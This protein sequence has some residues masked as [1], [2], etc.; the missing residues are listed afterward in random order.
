MRFKHVPTSFDDGTE[1]VTIIIEDI[2][3]RRL[4]EEALVDREQQYRRIIDNM[5]D[6]FYRTDKD[7]NLV[8]ISPGWAP[9]LGYDSFNSVIGRNLADVFYLDPSRR[10]DFLKALA[11]TGKVRDYEV[12]LKKK[13]G[14]PINVEVNS[15]YY[16][17]SAGNVLGVE[18]IAHDISERKTAAAEI[19]HFQSQREFL[20][21]TLLELIELPSTADIYD[22]IARDLRVLAPEAVICIASY[23]Q[24]AGTITIRA[25][26]DES[27]RDIGRKCLLRD[28]VGLESPLD[29][30]AFSTLRR[31]VPRQI[32]V[33]LHE[34]TGNVITEEAGR[35]LVTILDSEDLY[36]IGL[37]RGNNILG[38]AAFLQKRGAGKPDETAINAYVNQV[39]IVLQRIH[40]EEALRESEEKYRNLADGM[41][42]CVFIIDRDDII[43]YV[44]PAAARFLHASSDEITGKPRSLFFPPDISQNQRGALNNVLDNGKTSHTEVQSRVDNIKFWQ[45]NTLVPL[46]DK[47]GVPAAVL[48]ISRD[49]TERKEAEKPGNSLQPSSPRLKM[50]LSG[51]TRT[52]RSSAGIPQQNISTDTGRRRSLV[53]IFWTSSLRHAVLKWRLSWSQSATGSR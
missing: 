51:R 3:A 44:N 52:G 34:I 35:N 21:R 42:D 6:A 1:G 47:N 12:V 41:P 7:G 27:A 28:P 30:V 13:D 49:I 14:T 9:L 15:H 29:T 53:K 23:T 40:A 5:Q 11:P 36:S 32:P 45:E 33:S 20:S 8:M 18:G 24:A 46:M 4:A 31:G 19:Q 25:V 37:T 50:L 38:C 2:T 26:A 39:P 43:R 16:Y 17:D 48:G 22:K 10:K